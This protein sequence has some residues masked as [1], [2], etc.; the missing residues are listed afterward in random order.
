MTYLASKPKTL[1]QDE[2]F[3]DQLLWHLVYDRDFLRRFGSHLTD[4]A[5]R[6]AHHDRSEEANARWVVAEF[7]LRFF[8]QSGKPIRKLLLAEVREYAESIGER[9]RAAWEAYCRKLAKLKPVDSEWVAS[10]VRRFV[11]ERYTTAFIEECSEAHSTGVLDLSLL[12]EKFER[13][14]QVCSAVIETGVV[15]NAT[16][17]RDRE[18]S[19]PAF[20]IN[21]LAPR[22]LGL[23]LG[24]PKVGKSFLALQL[25]LA[26]A[27]RRPFLGRKVR[28]TGRV[29]LLALED[30]ERRLAERLG[31]LAPQ[32]PLD[33]LEILTAVPPLNG[34][35]LHQLEARLRRASDSEEPYCLVVIDC[36]MTAMAER[37]RTQ[38]L[39]RND[40]AEL[41]AL[42]KLAAQFETTI[43]AVHHLRKASAA[44]ALEAAIGTTGVTA[45]ID[46]S[47][48]MLPETG[49]RA[50]RFVAKGR[51]LAERTMRL[52]LD[53]TSDKPG[54]QVVAEG[55]EAKSGPVQSKILALLKRKPMTATTMARKLHIDFNN[56]R[57]VLFRM[58]KRGLVAKEDGS[59][60]VYPHD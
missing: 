48:A 3:L 38:D 39:V 35:G 10:K 22:G 26:V 46:W 16:K 13:H 14:M 27:L 50:I 29:L 5:F 56:V 49:T 42:R 53:L 32:V 57:Q 52:R 2:A 7:A 8:S 21:P 54:W 34:V 36:L 45:P 20:L 25:G 33:N 47:W 41:A 58:R 23:L 18:F 60:Y 30:T 43:V 12:R 6:P 24:R 1:W 11:M 9:K 17:L 15:L 4:G 40:Y 44:D 28:E 31:K 51:D 59:Q 55:A 19:D 37:R